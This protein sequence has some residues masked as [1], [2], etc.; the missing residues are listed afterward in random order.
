MTTWQRLK[1]RLARHEQQLQA[2]KISVEEFWT[3]K[4]RTDRPAGQF[5]DLRTAVHFYPT[6]TV[7][8]AKNNG[9]QS[10]IKRHTKPLNAVAGGALNPPWVEWLMGWPVGWTD[11]KRLGMD[12]FQQWLQLHGES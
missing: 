12:K 8:D 4:Q 10:Q 2:G 7:Q 3:K 11:L 9:G 6:P 5:S 1:T